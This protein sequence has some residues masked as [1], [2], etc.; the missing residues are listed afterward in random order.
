MAREREFQGRTL[1]EAIAEAARFLSV[2]EEAVHYRLVDEG[3]LGVLGFGARP[4]RIVVEAPERSP[5]APAPAAKAPEANAPRASAPP[6][7]APRPPAETTG[8]DAEPPPALVEAVRAILE[9]AGFAVAPRIE[10]DG[11]GWSIRLEGEDE[12]LFLKREA[13]L[14]HAFEFLLHRMSRRGWPDA[15][16]VRVRCGEERGGDDGEVAE[17]A[18]EVASVVARTGKPRKLHPMNP[19]ERR[20]VHVTV[21]EFPGL[22]SRSE[23]EGFLKR[24]TVEREGRRRGRRRG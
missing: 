3:R 14:L 11:A 23:G 13:E 18:R 7:E 4:V 1:E 16:P 19:Y 22:S 6:P 8:A 10:R 20:I 2:P 5:H 12:D 24:V 17:L 21:R 15:G 9:S